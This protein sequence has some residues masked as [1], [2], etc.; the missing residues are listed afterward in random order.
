MTKIILRMRIST[1]IQQ[2]PHNISSISLDC[3]HKRA[4]MT[5]IFYVRVGT[6]I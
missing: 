6:V 5:C 3:N 1:F 2:Y 4:L